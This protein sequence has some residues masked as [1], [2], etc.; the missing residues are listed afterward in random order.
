[1]LHDVAVFKRFSFHNTYRRFITMAKKVNPIP[2]GYRTITPC[3]V[4]SD[5]DRAIDFYTQALGAEQ[6]TQVNDLSDS[7]AVQASVKIGN[8]VIILQS[9]NLASGLLSPLSQA[10]GCNQLHLYV[11]DIDALWARALA[12]GAIVISEP[13]DTYWGDRNG[14]LLDMFGHRWSLASRIEHVSKEEAKKRLAQLHAPL[15]IVE[16][17]NIDVSILPNTLTEIADAVH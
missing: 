11:E 3:L 2:K 15:E 12:A 9:E 13:V 4:V 17:V 8:S 5:V 7:F 10:N 16:P 14:V 6:I 1:M